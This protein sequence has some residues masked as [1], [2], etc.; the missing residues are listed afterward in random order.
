MRHMNRRRR[1]GRTMIAAV[2]CIGLI[3][4]CGNKKDEDA[5]GGTQGSTPVSEAPD[6]S[7]GDTTA[8]TGVTEPTE[9]TPA[10][11]AKKPVYGGTLRVSGE[12]EV[13]NPWTPAA[14]QCDSY[15]QMRARSF[16]DPLVALNQNNELSGVLLESWE[17]NS[18]FTEWTFTVRDGITFHDGTPLDAAAVVD[19]LIRTGSGLLIA[20]AVKDIGKTADGKLA[21]EAT[22][23]MTFTVKTGKDGDLSQP[24]PW[25]NLPQGLTGQLGFVASPTWLKAVDADPTLA[26]KPVGTGPF[27]VESYASRESLV[28]VRNENYWMKDADGNQLPYLDGIEFRV[29]EDGQTTANALRNGDIDI[30]STSEAQVVADFREEADEFPMVEQDTLTETNY[31]LINLAQPGP[32]QDKRVRC[33]LSQAINREELID[34]T[35]GGILQPANGLF[36]PGQEGYLEDNGFDTGQDLEAAKAAIEEYEA[37]TGEQVTFSYGFTTSQVNETSYELYKGWWEEIGVD[38]TDNRVP[39]DAFITNALFGDA[40]FFVYGWRNHAGVSVD[41]QYFWWHSS[42]AAP[43]GSLAL[44]FGRLN[45]PEVDRNLEIARSATD[46]ADRVE[47]AEAINKRMAE[48]CFQIP[49]SWTL[50]GT[51]HVPAVQGLNTLVLP[52]GERSRDGAGFSGQFYTHSIWLDPEA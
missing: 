41:S 23:P 13:A 48:E 14:M 44:N 46:P 25:P 34:A 29:I 50:W 35:A 28:V 3:A 26:T 38:V 5:G 9:T 1:V 52:D 8:T 11:P 32:L 4:A 20:A 33:A 42:A 22:G 12:A 31:M 6:G 19:N 47:A 37:E 30:F 7:S 10:E 2:A 45:D 27:K 17:S 36:S 16:Y 40:N 49:T 43:L 51:P 24:L 15:C 39:Q 18:D 21:V